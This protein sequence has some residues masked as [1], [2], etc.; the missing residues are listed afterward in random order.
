M[1]VRI[2]YVNKSK[3]LQEQQD[4]IASNAPENIK[5]QSHTNSGELSPGVNEGEKPVKRFNFP[6]PKHT[7]VGLGPAT[8][9]TGP[10]ALL[11]NS[12]STSSSRVYHPVLRSPMKFYARPVTSRRPVTPAEVK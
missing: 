4:F 9:Y 2:R 5:V 7:H 10:S 11:N 1:F 12:T 3:Y 8:R 6:A